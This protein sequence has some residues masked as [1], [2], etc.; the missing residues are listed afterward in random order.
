MNKR[1]FIMLTG[2][3]LLSY[4]RIFGQGV[5]SVNNFTGAASVTIPLYNVTNG[6]LSVP[7]SVSYNSNG[8]KVKEVEGNAGI[9][10]NVNIG[11]AVYRTV[12]DLPDDVKKD[13]SSHD[14]KGW[15]YNTNSTGIGNFAFHNTGPDC[16][17]EAWD[18]SYINSNFNDLSDTEPDEFN[19]IAPGL[20]CR[21]YLD[22]AHHFRASP[23]RDYKVSTDTDGVGK[24]SSFTITNDQGTTYIFDVIESERKN[25]ITSGTVSFFKRDYSLYRYGITYYT[26]W[27]LS[28]I[29]DMRGNSVIFDYT[30]APDIYRSTPIRLALGGSSTATY[31]FETVEYMYTKYLTTISVSSRGGTAKPVL[32][33]SYY[34]YARIGTV[35]S[36][37]MGYGK[38]VNFTYT[39]PY[40]RDGSEYGREFLTGI[41]VG[42]HQYSFTYKGLQMRGQYHPVISLPDSTS[43]KL[44]YWGYYTGS[45]NT[46]LISSVY[47]NPSDTTLERY[48]NIY[49]GVHNFDYPYFINGVSRFMVPDS[50][51]IGL[52][53]TVKYSKGGFTVLKYEPNQFYDATADSYTYGSGFRVRQIRDYNGTDTTKAS[54]RDYSYSDASGNGSGRALSMP[55]FQFTTPYSGGGTTQAQWENSTIRS[56]DD[57]SPEDKSIVYGMVTVSQPGAGKTRYEYTT[58]ATFWDTSYG[59]DWRPTKVYLA[60]PSCT[61]LS[62]ATNDKNTYPFPNNTNYDFER[63]LL[64]R[65]TAFNSAGDT[66]SKTTYTYTRSAT[67]FRITAF[68]F[69][70][71]G[72]DTA[73]AKYNILTDVDNLTTKVVTKVYDLNSTT[74]YKQ[75]TVDYYYNSAYHKLMTKQ[76]STS[77]DGSV[78]ITNIKYV[79]DYAATN[80]GTDSV[81][82]ALYHMQQMNCNIPVETYQQVQRDSLR[83]VG[84]SLVKFKTFAFSGYDDL[85][86]PAHKLSYI[87]GTGVTN[88][89]PSAIS[90]NVFGSDSRYFVTENDVM[91][92]YRG[93]LQTSNDNNRHTNTVLTDVMAQQPA[94][95]FANAT[96]AEVGFMNYDADIPSTAFDVDPAEISADGRTGKGLA[97]AYTDLPS[98][99]FTKSPRANNY[100]FSIWIKAS[101]GGT[102]TIT[103]TSGA[104]SHNYTF[105]YTGGSKYNYYQKALPLTGMSST[106]TLSYQPGN[107]I[108]TDDVAVYPDC[109]QA[110]ITGY[111]T[112]SRQKIAETNTNG[113]AA[114]YSYDSF[115]RPLAVFDN[116][117]NMVK[118]MSYVN[119]NGADPADLGT[120]TVGTSSSDKTVNFYVGI[121]DADNHTGLRYRWNFGDDTTHVTTM[122]GIISHVYPA[123]STY[124]YTLTISSPYYPDETITG[125]VTT[126]AIPDPGSYPLVTAT[127]LG[128]GTGTITAV[129][130]YQGSTLAYSFSQAQMESGTVYVA[131]G[132]YTVII[133]VDGQQY[134]ESLGTGYKRAV[135][136]YNGVEHDC[137]PFAGHSFH[138]N[139]SFSVDLTSSGITSLIFA[140]DT[141]NCTPES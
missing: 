19:V 65:Q 84:A 88:F 133:S 110:A 35:V 28:S 119:R 123:Y 71:N 94:A 58:P 114:Y 21:L 36:G 126:S 46:S 50:A 79:K 78:N 9:S 17:N 8:V 32:G 93:Y 80:S 74:L 135:V 89:T 98:R 40:S 1:I 53:D 43:K 100:I 57:L 111:D 131:P 104:T 92:D 107:S 3:I 103:L 91:Y 115:W 61:T 116:D 122:S 112:V 137:T 64:T 41:D 4:C 97:L 77:S 70:S 72:T 108:L 124:N 138:Q 106:F 140:L 76:Q 69:S 67:P 130:F 128:D 139:Y 5:A 62:F 54:V 101:S 63:G 127:G 44:D 55:Q 60:R 87:S 59:T 90:S 66:V 47:V 52:M 22:S 25:T 7:V 134:N 117:H 29:T 132:N 37:I 56:E 102:M 10:W 15:L 38:S 45:S 31:Q 18:I 96:A 6:S 75:S 68:K 99:V 20:S 33:F 82:L 11:G 48:R 105:A 73:Y 42:D 27:K 23:Y 85:Y 34:P 125:S 136:Y 81:N 113:K 12:R 121:P 86:L 16:T 30:I 83:T 95:A 24:I 120:A 129:Q 13:E 141:T 51:K 109:A 49:P 39:N 26:A 14:R 2:M 118:R